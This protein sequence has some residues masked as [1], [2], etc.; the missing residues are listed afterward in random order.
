MDRRDKTRQHLLFLFRDREY[1]GSSIAAL[2]DNGGGR[3]T[4]YE[5]MDM[6]TD[7]SVK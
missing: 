6:M 2:T 1:C 4:I 5:T 3:L 7:I